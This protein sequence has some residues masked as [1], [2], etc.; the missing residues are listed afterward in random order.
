VWLFIAG[1][2]IVPGGQT[3][4]VV[5]FGD[6][7]TEGLFSTSNTNTR[8]PDQLARRLMALDPS[9]QMGVV[10]VGISG[11][12]I[13]SGAAT[14]PNA[15]WRFDPDAVV[16]PG[17][18]HVIV[19]LGI[20]DLNGGVT[21][22]DVI[23]AH[24]QLISRAHSRD[25]K[26]I[27][28]TITPFTNAS[29]TVNNA[30]LV[31]NDFIRNSGEFDGI[32]DF[33]LAIRDPANPNR[34]LPAYNGDGI[35]LHP[36][37]TGYTVMGNAINLDLLKFAPKVP[38]SDLPPLQ[39]HLH[40][41]PI[42]LG[43]ASGVVTVRLM[44]PPPWDLREWGISD[45]KAEG[46]PAAS[47]TYSTDG[48]TLV[49]TFRNADLT[50]LRTGDVV[51][52]TVTGTFNRGGAQAALVASTAVQ[53]VG[54]QVA[55]L[56]VRTDRVDAEEADAPGDAQAIDIEEFVAREIEAQQAE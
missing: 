33:D 13:T 38:R 55:A 54:Q 43:N 24:R 22:A 53:V 45:I 44:A 25:M 56:Q 46:A 34:M 32:A 29:A 4:T 47:A 3:G 2:D 14:N 16:R 7:I 40:P 5:A 10:D 51:T 48:R 26:I 9:R 11:N 20:N 41:D 8:W 31:V 21:A 15:L 36:N 27:G 12:R 17:A 37:S 1:T 35:G 19:L 30:R 23:A 42:D 18:S 28:G 52:F 6:S 50:S 39:P 49:V